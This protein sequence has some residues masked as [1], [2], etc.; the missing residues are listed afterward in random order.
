MECHQKAYLQSKGIKSPA[1][2]LKMFH[3]GT[4]VDRILRDWLKESSPQLGVMASRVEQYMNLVEQEYVE[5]GAGV[6]RWEHY[7]ERDNSISWCKKLL[8]RVEPLMQELVLPYECTPDFR[9]KTPIMIPNLEG[10]PTKVNLIGAIDI[11]VKETEDRYAVYDL[12]AT[13]NATYWKKTIMQLVFYSLAMYSI[14]GYYPVK[15]ALIQP[16]CKDQVL[17]LRITEEHILSL[18]NKITEY[19]HSVW[20]QDFS[21]KESDTGCDWCPVKFACSKF[22]RDK[23]KRVSF[24]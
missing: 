14:T 10:V 3:K 21:P 13:E 8:T 2:N 15:N 6:V 7:T 11:V 12:K 17:S 5:Q 23:D 1:Q 9:F 19:A 4:T 20:R 22:A 24:T 16:M 18:V